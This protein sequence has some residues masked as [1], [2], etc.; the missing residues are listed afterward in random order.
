ME[1][2]QYGQAG[3][4]AIS[5]IALNVLAKAAVRKSFAADPVGTLKGAGIDP[6][7]VPEEFLHVLADMSYEELTALSRVTDSMINAGISIH[8][9][10]E[11]LF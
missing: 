3:V 9:G 6:D 10:P 1:Q 2:G 11:L 4:E 7:S 5:Q 8:T